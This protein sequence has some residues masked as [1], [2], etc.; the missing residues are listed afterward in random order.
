MEQVGQEE[1]LEGKLLQITIIS[2]G[3]LKE[4]YLIEGIN[5]YKKRLSAYIKAKI[6]EV[7]DIA[8]L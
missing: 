5:E 3:K 6:I 7:R 1:V 8:S 2:V 4:R